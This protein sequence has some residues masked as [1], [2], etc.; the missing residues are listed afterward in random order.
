MEEKKDWEPKA[1]RFVAFFDI[2][3]FKDLVFRKSH[4]EIVKLLDSLSEG[5]KTLDTINNF[6]MK[7]QKILG[8]TRSFSFSDSIIFFSKG[9]SADDLRKIMMDCVYVLH[10]SFNAQI[11]VKGAV[12]YGEITVDA[13]KSIFFGQ[14]IIDAHLLHEEL[15]MYSVIADNKFEKKAQ[16][17][18]KGDFGFSSG[19]E[20]YKTPLKSGKANHYVLNPWA[21]RKEFISNLNKLYHT[22]YGKPRQYIDNT[23]DYI[24]YLQKE[25]KF[26]E[27]ESKPIG[28]TKSS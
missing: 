5:R 1:Y 9:D 15:L 2:M 3:G 27:D 12:S 20:F 8:E 13:E 10:T 26:K 6:S 11:P 21:N 25:G 24:S 17:L 18:D 14:P 16:E 28:D 22:V 4:E 7:D 23:I 19:F